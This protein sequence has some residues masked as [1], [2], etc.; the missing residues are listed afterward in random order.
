[1]QIIDAQNTRSVSAVCPFRRI[2]VT[3]SERK[4]ENGLAAARRVILAPAI[5]I[6]IPP[7]LF[8]TSVVAVA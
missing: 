5:L 6:A 4:R 1:M 8:R 7:F 3:Q 2:A